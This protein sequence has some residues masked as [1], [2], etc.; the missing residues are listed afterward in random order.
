MGNTSLAD[1]YVHGFTKIEQD[2]L[3]KQAR[4]LEESIFSNVDFSKA[5]SIIEV[6]IGVGAQTQILLDRFPKLKV[7]G[8]DASASQVERARI[9]LANHIEI[10]RVEVNVGDA[11]HLNY[12]E[13][14]FDGAFICWFLEHVQKPIEILKEVRR[15]LKPGGILYCNEPLNTNLYIH[16]YSPATLKFW[17]EFNDYQW[18][19]K[20][21]PFVGGKLGNYLQA[22][23]YQS[24]E[25]KVLTSHYDNRMPKKRSAYIDYWT[26]L[27]LSAAPGLIEAGR[28]DNDIVRDM[29][30]ELQTLKNDPDSVIYDSWILARAEAH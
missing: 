25:T 9:A 15:V 5:E 2:R 6:G 3:F 20:G 7:F 13:N 11:L 1:T 22:A 4:I 27:M 21:D 26:D 17:F 19:M 23:G 8:L 14:N 12:E 24:I 29:T 30:L 16:P 18:T 28:V 10:G